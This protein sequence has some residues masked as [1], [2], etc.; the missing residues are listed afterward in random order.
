V[1]SLFE[2]IRAALNS[3]VGDRYVMGGRSDG[4]AP[5]DPAGAYVGDHLVREVEVAPG[6]WQAASV[7]AGQALK[8]VTVGAPG[9]DV[10]DTLTRLRT[11]LQANDQAG[12]AAVL[13]DLAAGTDQVATLRGQVGVAMSGFDTAV[14]VNGLAEDDAVTMAAHLT[15]ADAIQAATELA[16]AQRGLEASLTAT[17]KSFRL[18]LLDYLK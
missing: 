4:V 16:L 3:K 8:G 18:S 12:T 10:L 15:D 6:V 11:A 9:V 7:Q 5:F 13:G 14:A 2:T 17:S 1:A